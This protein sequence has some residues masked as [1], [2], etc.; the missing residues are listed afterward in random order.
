MA[1]PVGPHHDNP[2]ARELW[3]RQGRIVPGKPGAAARLLHRAYR[4]KMGMRAVRLRASAGTAVSS[5]SATLAASTTSATTTSS[6]YGGWVPLGPNPINSNATGSLDEQ[7]YGPVTG[8]ATSVVVDPGDPTGNTVYLGGAFGGLWKSTNAAAA[9]PSTVVWTPL[10]DQQATLAVGAV[11]VQPSSSGPSQVILVGTGE[12]DFSIDSYYGLGILRSTDAGTSWTLVNSDNSGHSFS[13]LAFAKIAFST[14]N[15]NLV[16][17]AAG[18]AGNDE[19]ASNMGSGN[20]PGLYTSSDGGLTWALTQSG[21]AQGIGAT[22]VFFDSASLNFF[23]FMQFEGY[24]SSRD[25]LTWARLASQPGTSLQNCP[26]GNFGVPVCYVFRGEMAAVPGREELYTWYVTIDQ[27]GNIDDGGIYRTINAGSSWQQVNDSGITNCG[28]GSGNGCGAQQGWFNLTLAAVPHGTGTDLYAGAVNLFKCSIA[29]GN[30]LCGVKPFI[31]LTHVYGCTPL[32]SL[33]HVHPDQ[34]GISFL[35]LNASQVVMYFAN[36]GGIYRALNGY[37]LNSG[38]CGTTPNP[39]QD[40][41]A[42]M[43][44]MSQFVD[45]SNSP[46][47]SA[48]LLGGTQD[49]GS[50][51]TN[52][53]YGSSWISV[54]GGDGGF[55]AIDPN[56]A[57]TWFT[58]NTDVSVQR[59]ND[60]VNCLAQTF[61]PIVTNSTV[62]GDHGFFYTPFILDSQADSRMMVGTCRLWRGNSDGSGFAPLS[63][64]FDTVLSQTPNQACSGN[65]SQLIR[66]IAAG[67]PNTGNGSSVIYVG[68]EGGYDLV[69]GNS[70]GGHIWVTNNA[71]LGPFTWANSYPVSSEV[72]PPISS[73]AVDPR[74]TTGNTAYATLLGFGIGQVIKTTD[75]GMDWFASQQLPDAPV[76]TIVIDPDDSNT[77]YAG[78][79]V[80]VY[81]THDLQNWTELGQLP[82]VPV[83]QLKM[84]ESGGVKQLRA[85]TYGRGIWSYDIPYQIKITTPHLYLFPGQKGTISGVITGF[86]GYSSPVSIA[87]PATVNFGTCTGTTVTPTPSGTAF[88][89]AIAAGSNVGWTDYTFDIQGTGAD[90]A[91]TVETAAM[92]VTVTN[93]NFGGTA[94][95]TVN[96]GATSGTQTFFIGLFYEPITFSCANL[97][98]GITCNF[99]PSS[100]LQSPNYEL[101]LTLSAD[102]NTVPGSYT[103]QVNSTTAAQSSPRV[104]S[105]SLTVTS[106]PDYSL[107]VTSPPGTTTP[108]GSGT[109]QVTLTPVG[110]YT[111][112]VSLSCSAAYFS[113]SLSPAGPVTF[114]GAPI[115]VNVTASVPA[116]FPYPAPAGASTITLTATGQNTAAHYANINFPVTD[117]TFTPRTPSSAIRAGQPGQYELFVSPSGI[118]FTNPVSFSCSGLPKG[119]ACSFSPATVTPNS[120]PAIVVLSVST[121]KT[122]AAL[123]PPKADSEGP[124]MLALLVPGIVLS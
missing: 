57:D 121:T 71:D 36:D 76:N 25:G 29:A 51:A 17:A 9:D 59:C 7:N 99:F 89:L 118:P 1:Q 30:G 18:G 47:D 21:I 102:L 94:S 31:N 42:T 107:V 85:G 98:P 105:V 70:V 52:A 41:N 100:V 60:G 109:G 43:G 101:S 93:Y 111:G 53:T 69:S 38:T 81:T 48:T 95:F 104:L 27:Q 80:G 87:C 26:T 11:A 14:D 58:S 110:N 50:P 91:A 22:S 44:S 73:I 54:N 90:P 117:F 39:F 96:Q 122:L 103:F 72:P 82:N 28:D 119:A 55:N 32:G 97:P 15:P 40:L 83:L 120:S 35:R 114:T 92:T 37:A 84:F 8:R 33:S 86:N 56:N 66:S 62:G 19:G 16:V 20:T 123:R 12:A 2:L 77:L 124:L 108:G 46:S 24:F 13:G 68:T 67:G 116:Y 4:Q 23:A 61:D 64:N 5:Y 78:T 10:I 113:C 3:F 63:Y 34:H 49:N 115:A 88:S 75:Q 45:F 6:G 74:D 112:P 79:D 65:E 106:N